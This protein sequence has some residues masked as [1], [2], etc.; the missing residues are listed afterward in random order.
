MALGCLAGRQS[1]SA[2]VLVFVLCL[3][4]SVTRTIDSLLVYN[5]HELLKIKENVGFFA[6]FGQG[7]HTNSPPPLLS[8]VPADLLRGRP[9][10][11]RRRRGTRS[12]RLVRVKEWLACS[13]ELAQQPRRFPREYGPCFHRLVSRRPL[14]MVGTWLV[15]VADPTQELHVLRP[16]WSRLPPLM[17]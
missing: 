1:L 2:L 14:A 4:C 16:Q 3:F 17:E 7:G 6:K 12:G 11:P 10:L 5:R 8:D 13:P 9:L 15:P